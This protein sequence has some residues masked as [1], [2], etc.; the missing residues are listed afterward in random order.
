MSGS[1]SPIEQSVLSLDALAAGQIARIVRV[2]SREP[3]LL[4]KLAGLGMVPGAVVHLQQ[5]TPATV[6]SLGETTVAFDP[7]IAAEIYVRRVNEAT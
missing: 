1:T 7:S 5:K 2:V 3:G 6:V 4:V